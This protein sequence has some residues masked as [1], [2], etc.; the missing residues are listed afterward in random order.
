MQILLSLLQRYFIGKAQ[1]KKKKKRTKK[2]LQ[3]LCAG[4]S[5]MVT[6]RIVVEFH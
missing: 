3:L 2:N 1:G 4:G 5:G 6:Q